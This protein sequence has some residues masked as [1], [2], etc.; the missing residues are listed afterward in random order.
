[1]VFT[2]TGK[3]G[4]FF[5]TLPIYSKYYLDKG[6][7]STIVFPSNF[8][9]ANVAI[10]FCKRFDFI[11]EIVI[12]NFAVFHFDLGGVPYKF[13]PNEYGVHCDSWYNIGYRDKPDGT[14]AAKFC[15]DE[16][17]LGYEE[18]FNIQIPFIPELHAKYKDVIAFADATPGRDDYDV[19]GQLMEKA[20]IPFHTFDI[21]LPI[22][23]NLLIAKHCK[24]VICAGSA[25]S[26][27]LGFTDIPFSVFTW[28][29]DPSVFYGYN[30]NISY[31]EH[32]PFD[33]IKLSSVEI[34]SI[35]KIEDTIKMKVINVNPGIIEIPPKNWG[36]IEKII[37]N[38]HLQLNKIG[39]ESEILYLD[40]VKYDP[41]TIV[42]IHVTNLANIAH[43]R[44]LQYFFSLHDHHALFEHGNDGYIEQT[45]TAIQNSIKT[46]VH[47]NE[48]SKHPRFKDLAHKF[49]YVQHGADPNVYKTSNTERSKDLLCV[50]SNGLINYRYFDRKGFL[51][52]S[53]VAN[54]LG[55]KLTICCPSNTVDFL[56]KY[57]LM[58]D[59]NIDIKI[60]L[61]EEQLVSE[62]QTH[63]VFLHPSVLEAGHPNLTL[64]EAHLCGMKI[65]GSYNGEISI[66]GMTVANHLVPNSY[67]HAVRTALEDTAP[68]IPSTEF[69]WD[70]I[71][72]KLIGIY[73][74]HGYTIR[75]FKDSLLDSYTNRDTITHSV[76]ADA[77]VT[78]K[79][80]MVPSVDIKSLDAKSYNVKFATVDH[81]N[82]ETVIYQTSLSNN[83]WARPNDAYAKDWRVYVNDELKFETKIDIG[84]TVCAV[85]STYP[86]SEDVK[87]KTIQTLTN[88]RDNIGVA[89][90]CATH[91]DYPPSPDE[92]KNA[93][94]HYV[95]NPINTLTT[96]T[97]Y[98]YYNGLHDVNDKTFKVNLD[99][100][101]SGNAGYHGPA[102]HQNYYNGVK[103]AKE[104]GFKYAM[105][106]N[107]DMLFSKNDL[108]KIGCI[109][110][111]VI[112][113][114]S[115]G[116]FFYTQE[117]EGPTYKTVFCVVNVD[118]FLNTFSEI[119][120]EDDYN[121]FVKEVGSESN[122]L[123]NVYYH[124][125][126]NVEE[127]VIKEIAEWQF[128]ESAECFTNSQANY[129]AV[130]PLTLKNGEEKYA[131]FIRRPN[132]NVSP[133]KLKLERVVK[134]NI[135]FDV[136]TE[137]FNIDGEFTTIIP[138]GIEYKSSKCT[139]QLIDEYGNITERIIDDL[140]DLLKN[141]SI[142]ET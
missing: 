18:T 42:H 29:T 102:V 25:L 26:V 12:S 24:K 54:A 131:V 137:E 117:P 75:G 71:T 120:N 91:I 106:T 105:L 23:E 134:R 98:R 50:A 6:E 121:N 49:I 118:M 47:T 65:V 88:I 4:D 48:F 67:E 17:N 43:E 19:L 110:N 1:M 68:V 79:F 5:T 101:H 51:L 27:L 46:I 97:Y 123:E 31:I 90:I 139:V 104:L 85:V 58:N 53:Q 92:I 36:A 136:Y 9:H 80:D 82:E 35:L 3:L 76:K 87:N 129:L 14:Y 70:T 115:N 125:L 140:N 44:G 77:Q 7:K 133:Y 10:D 41:Y 94:N 15:A 37:W 109:L 13:N 72:K 45:R 141:G 57:N 74:K 2:H 99:L 11:E 108:Y 39:I 21:S 59:P 62:Y 60:D 89:T 124:A 116:F 103:R 96:H 78:I 111:T 122:S 61:S 128:F 119:S 114:N 132:K 38:Y 86:N 16:H 142:I 112:V 84:N 33:I 64:A 138:F 20:G 63:K 126:K 55:K 135:A 22:Y 40:D 30:K 83:M 127:L 100:L 93:S 52:A 95:L 66:P 130:M 56:I 113:N 107:F 81:H 8:P 69:V 73:K 34:R 32:T 28:Q